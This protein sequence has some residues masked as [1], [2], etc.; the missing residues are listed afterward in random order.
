MVFIRPAK[1]D[2]F[3]SEWRVGEEFF[4]KKNTIFFIWKIIN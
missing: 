2:L 3:L 4:L 1:T